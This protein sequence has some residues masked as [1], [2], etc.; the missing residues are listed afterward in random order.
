MEQE[1][2]EI[3]SQPFGE[4]SHNNGEGFWEA[5]Q[6]IAEISRSIKVTAEDVERMRNALSVLFTS[7]NFIEEVALFLQAYRFRSQF[8][9]LDESGRIPGKRDGL[10][11]AL[12]NA[13][14]LYSLTKEVD[15]ARRPDVGVAAEVGWDV[16]WKLA[17]ETA[18]EIVLSD[19]KIVFQFKKLLAIAGQDLSTLPEIEVLSHVL[20]AIRTYYL[21]ADLNTS[22]DPW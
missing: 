4:D 2:P 14:E 12:R 3:A 1:P 9:W 20:K 17:L 7:E 21:Y 13:L 22:S 11:C 10:V 18:L 8:P 6:S 16:D 5:L 15:L 19:R